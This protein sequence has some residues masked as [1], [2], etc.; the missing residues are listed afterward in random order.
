MNTKLVVFDLAGT[1]V[2][3]S[4]NVNDSFRNA[5]ISAGIEVPKS[6]VD[7]LMGYRKIE[8]ISLIVDK[9]RP[10]I[11]DRVELIK[12]LHDDFNDEMVDF[13]LND[14]EIMPLPHAEDIFEWLNQQG[15]KVGLNTGFTRRITN[16]ILQ[17][18]GWDQD[19]FVNIVVCSDEV[20]EGRPKPFMIQKMLENLSITSPQLVVKVGDTEVDVLEGRKAGCGVVV[21]VTTGAYTREQL[22]TYNPDFIIDSLLELHAIIK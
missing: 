11:S 7:K 1:T 9:Y 13:Y 4:G 19:P 10:N 6:E 3:D 22:K 18:L 5:F 16:A 21:S 12:K 2:A 17:R 15:V 8:A 20:P 14:P